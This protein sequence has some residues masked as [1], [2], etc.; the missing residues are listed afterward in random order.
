M[1]VF[2][3][4]QLISAQKIVTLDESVYV[5]AN[6][7][8]FVTG[9]T[10]LYKIYCLKSSDKTP[11]IISKIA[12][13]ELVDSNKKSVFKTKI[14]LENSYGQGDYF[15]PTTLKTGNY[16]LIGYTDWMLNKPT[17]DLFQ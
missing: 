11:S 6:A 1:F 2:I 16:K 5:H 9:E 3:N 14:A 12:Y 15:I 7:S 10:L 17:S 4:T 8:T 13:V